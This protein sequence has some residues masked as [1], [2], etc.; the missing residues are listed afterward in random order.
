MIGPRGQAS[1]TLATA[2]AVFAPSNNS[3]AVLT[4]EQTADPPAAWMAAYFIV[5]IVF[6]VFARWPA[7][8]CTENLIRV[9]DAMESP[10]LAE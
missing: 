9:D 4:C 2:N 10:K 1:A 3:D 5:F 6:C 7:G 8:V